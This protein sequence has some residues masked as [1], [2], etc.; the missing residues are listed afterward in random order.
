MLHVEPG[1]LVGCC[2]PLLFKAI[3]TQSDAE[4]RE[5]QIIPTAHKFSGAE[6]DR[7]TLI[8]LLS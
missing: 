7:E 3:H 6:A 1:L 5:V 4:L 2:E 8:S